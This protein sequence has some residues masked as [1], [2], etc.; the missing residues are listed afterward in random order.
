MAPPHASFAP[1][2]ARRGL[3]TAGAAT[4]G[5]MLLG[6]PAR[7]AGQS[8]TSWPTVI[9]LPDGFR[10]EGIA[11]GGGPYAYLG[12]LGDGSVYRADLRTGEGR[13]IS[14]GPGTPSVGLKPD[15]KGRLFVARSGEGARVIDVRSGEIL[16]SYPLT[17]ATPT[18][19]NDV[20]LT[21][22]AA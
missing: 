11:I 4:A 19:V 7:A 15:D 10:P 22:R 20:F 12:S 21:P 16:A 13:V 2:P 6:S 14:V 5:A 3:L 1:R 17:T 8:G 18:F 9:P